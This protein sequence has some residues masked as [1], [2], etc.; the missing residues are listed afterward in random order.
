VRA[1]RTFTPEEYLLIEGQAEYKP[2]KPYA[3]DLKVKFE[4]YKTID[5]LQEYLLISQGEPKFEIFR[6]STEGWLN[7]IQRGSIELKS[8]G[9]VLG[10][11]DVYENVKF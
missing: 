5:S 6:R 2:C 11:G 4:R 10:V 3:V 8:I 1:L 7:D 9:C